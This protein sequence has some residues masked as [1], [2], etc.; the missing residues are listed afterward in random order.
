MLIEGTLQIIAKN[1][2]LIILCLYFSYIYNVQ[3]LLLKSSQGYTYYIRIIFVLFCFFH[4]L[5]SLLII[6]ETLQ[7]IVRS[8]SI[9]KIHSGVQDSNQNA[10]LIKLHRP[11]DECIFTYQM[12]KYYCI[13]KFKIPRKPQIMTQTF[14]EY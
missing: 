4:T 1:L 12:Q 8:T 14:Y 11:L 13:R 6:N 9:E 10:I 5:R 3:C 2:I 7:F